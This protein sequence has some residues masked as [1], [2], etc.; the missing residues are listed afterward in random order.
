MKLKDLKDYI[1]PNSFSFEENKELIEGHYV[2]YVDAVA[3]KGHYDTKN[4]ISRSKANYIV[5]FDS[6]IKLL[7]WRRI[8]PTIFD[9]GEGKAI[10]F[11]LSYLLG[12]KIDIP[13]IIFSDSQPM[14]QVV[15]TQKTTNKCMSF[16]GE[17]IKKRLLKNPLIELKK[18]KS[19]YNLSDRIW[20]YLNKKLDFKL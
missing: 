4:Y 20:Y 19:D 2:I 7:G 6:Q 9:V 3:N 11:G 8:M 1:F 10:F 17:K 13:I 14:L 16:W 15:E 18:I 12:L 5:L